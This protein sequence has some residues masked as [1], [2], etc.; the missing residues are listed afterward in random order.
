MPLASRLAAIAFVGILAGCGG[1]NPTKPGNNNNVQTYPT[2]NSPENALERLSL[3]YQ[4]RDSVE[5]RKLF[6]FDY[7]GT[8][9][10]LGDGTSVTL[11]NA[12]EVRHI[13]ALAKATSI[14]SVYLSMGTSSSW[15]RLPSDD[16]SHP[17][18]AVIKISGTQLRLQIDDTRY[19]TLLLGNPANSYTFRFKPTPPDTTTTD[20]LWTVIQWDEVANR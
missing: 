1:D 16:L 20:T 15:T 6:A 14:T 12:D 10:D 19:G 11:F 7:L 3:A 5:Y 8:S 13:Q 2:P 9:H 18:W 4:G 17:E